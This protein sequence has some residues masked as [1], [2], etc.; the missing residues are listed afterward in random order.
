MSFGERLA[1][2]AH[3]VNSTH[4]G[5]AANCSRVL[6]ARCTEKPPAPWHSGSP[7]LIGDTGDIL[8][9]SL[10]AVTTAWLSL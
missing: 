4:Y 2:V 1:L 10:T 7:T 5:L 8:R 6:R 3:K 9:C